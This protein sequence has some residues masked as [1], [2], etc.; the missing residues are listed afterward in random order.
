MIEG[1]WHSGKPPDMAAY[2]KPQRGK[3]KI[4]SSSGWEALA[5]IYCNGRVKGVI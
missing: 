1:G 4:D 5:C 3:H 2:E